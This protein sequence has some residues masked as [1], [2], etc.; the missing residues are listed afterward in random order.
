MS[1]IQNDL[2]PFRHERRAL[3]TELEIQNVDLRRAQLDIEESRNR[4]IDLYEFAPIGY[5]TLTRDGTISEVNL[6][7]AAL[8]GMARKKLVNRSF[9]S[10]IAGDDRGR[11]NSYFLN[12]FQSIGC[13]VCELVIQRKDGTSFHAQLDCQRKQSDDTSLMRIALTDITER[14]Q[15]AEKLR[16]SD[17]SLR[18]MLE[19]VADCAIF[20]LDTRGHVENWNSGAQLIYG[21]SAEEI[22]GQHF[23]RFYQPEDI[24]RGQPQRELDAVMAQERLEVEGWRVRKDGSSYWANVAISTMRNESGNLCGFVRLTRDVSEHRRQEQLLSDKNIE[25]ERAKAA[26][27]KANL[28]KSEFISRMSH[29]LRTPLNAILGFSQLLEASLLPPSAMQS[30]RLQQILKAGWY[31]LD[32]INEILDLAVIESGKLTLSPEPLSLA[33]VMLECQAIIEP[34]AQERDIKLIFPEFTIPCF[35]RADRIRLK[36][37]LINLLSNAIKYNRE[38]GMVEV[39]CAESAPGRIRICIKD[40]GMGLSPEKLSQLFQPFNRLGQENGIVEGTGIGLVVTRR[41]VDLMG[42]TIGVESTV[43]VGSEFWVELIQSNL[44]QLATGN[45]VPAEHS[46]Q[47]HGSSRQRIL[48]YVEDN[49]ANLLLVEQIIESHPHVNMLS[50]RDGNHGVALAR[51]HHPDV[52]LMDINLPGISG[53]EAMNIL[54]K[55]QT[56]KHIP[57]I[58]L[59][60]NAML[61]DI[62]KGLEA[63]FFRYLTKPIKIN[64]F[65]SALDGALGFVEKGL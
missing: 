3:Q 62:E 16:K 19:S 45:T 64:E 33:K 51:A 13:K 4:Y 2:A 48:L 32:L 26:A 65:M 15:T 34:Q 22:I 29:E 43:G 41:L 52:I 53:I 25:L 49:P 38:Q 47:T 17:A 37:V 44:P 31:L 35:V 27:E 5:L 63:G 59:S 14:I 58:A 56:T 28:A 24:N 54:R 1:N 7:G 8:L 18:L 60:A 30:I 9:D 50:A 20:M 12:L 11:W 46:P 6:T 42:G 40:N 23:S 21:Y 61:R 39:T 36:E 55:D 57:I 10:F